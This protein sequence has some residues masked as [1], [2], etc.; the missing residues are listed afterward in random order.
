MQLRHNNSSF[1][2]K[3][4]LLNNLVCRA[5]E[6]FRNQWYRVSSIHSEGKCAEHS[7]SI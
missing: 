7:K 1:C 6:K 2:T 4:Y 3:K 5:F